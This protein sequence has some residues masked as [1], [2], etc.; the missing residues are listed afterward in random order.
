MIEY[1]GRLDLTD[2]LKQFPARRYEGIIRRLLPIGCILCQPF[3]GKIIND[4][5]S[6]GAK[7]EKL[8]TDKIVRTC[9]LL[10]HGAVRTSPEVALLRATMI[11]V[12]D[13]AVLRP[14]FPRL[15]FEIFYTP[16]NLLEFLPNIVFFCASLM[17]FF[18]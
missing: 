10:D 5:I 18:P 15:R 11:G 17:S 7:Q 4:P 3:F 2:Y 12:A 1:Q 13:V 9:S 14:S 8:A 16:K 6:G